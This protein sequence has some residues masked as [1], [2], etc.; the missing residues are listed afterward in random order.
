MLELLKWFVGLGPKI[1]GE[2]A[3]FGQSLADD[4]R[5]ML[6]FRAARRMKITWRKPSW[7]EARTHDAHP[8]VGRF[9]DDSYATATVGGRQW[10]V[11]DRM[12]F[13]FPDSDQFV[14]FA[15]QGD[16]VWC[17]WDFADWPRRW[18]IVDAP[19]I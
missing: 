16:T 14:F 11:R 6:R 17:A 7:E 19:A 8:V 1:E 12:Y 15:L 3:G 5:F 9:G 13:G 2:D 10:I 4:A 18:S